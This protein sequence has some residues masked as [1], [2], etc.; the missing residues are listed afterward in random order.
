[1]VNTT[2]SAAETWPSISMNGSTEWKKWNSSFSRLDLR[3]L[4]NCDCEKVS[5]SATC[6]SL[7]HL[8]LSL[9]PV[10]Q[11][12]DSLYLLMWVLGLLFLLY[13][14]YAAILFKKNPSPSPFCEKLSLITAISN[15][16]HG[17]VPC[18]YIQNIQL[19]LMVT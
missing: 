17:W 13:Q 16:K 10:L 14:Y 11:M 8:S 7:L 18:K 2:P 12:A 15:T 19:I 1:M 4:S 3:F 6:S 5:S 9:P